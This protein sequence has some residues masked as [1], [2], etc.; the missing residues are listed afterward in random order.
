MSPPRVTA[1]EMR[2]EDSAR[3]SQNGDIMATPLLDAT[4]ATSGTQT[5]EEGRD[6]VSATLA[7]RLLAALPPAPTPAGRSSSGSAFSLSMLPAS[8]EAL[9]M[10]ERWL[11]QGPVSGDSPVAAIVEEEVGKSG[12]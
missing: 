10:L 9:S 6:A 3:A 2:A 12:G 11:P 5:P 1:A 4:D 8:S 7:D